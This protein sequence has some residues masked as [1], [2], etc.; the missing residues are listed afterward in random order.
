MPFLR[1]EVRPSFRAIKDTKFAKANEELLR[2]R[3]KEMR[4]LGREYVRFERVE[5]PEGKTGKFKRGLGFKTFQRG[6]TIVMTAHM[7][8]PLG[9][10]ITEGTKAHWIQA[11]NKKALFFMW[12]K[13]GGPVVVPKKGGFKTH[14]RKGTLWIGK[15]G[16]DHPG[17]EAN[18]FHKRAYRRWRPGARKAL[19]RMTVAWQ[20]GFTS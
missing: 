8:Q 15:G 12:P 9:R 4:Q 2:V 3:R 18:P 6:E 1:V 5:A 19:R 7:P 16:V 20:E 10:F 11:K 17:T 13:F 14:V